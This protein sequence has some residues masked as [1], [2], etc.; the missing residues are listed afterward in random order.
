MRPLIHTETVRNVGEKVIG[1]FREVGGEALDEL[2]S[3]VDRA[4][5]EIKIGIDEGLHAASQGINRGWGE[6][7]KS[8]ERTK[9][10]L[11]MKEPGEESA[12]RNSSERSSHG[13]RRSKTK[14]REKLN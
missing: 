2:K 4:W 14:E 1:I 6:L 12:E 3:G 13:K 11:M 7:S 8:L 5:D 9:D 10:N